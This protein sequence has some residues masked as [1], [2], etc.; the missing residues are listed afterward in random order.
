MTNLPGAH[1]QTTT[2]IRNIAPE[3]RFTTPRSPNA[4]PGKSEV[5]IRPFL[6]PI[7]LAEFL[8]P[9]E[10]ATPRDWE[11]GKFGVA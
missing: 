11:R 1:T 3:G 5:E 9:E 7:G 4:M 10:L 8:T 2:A 6:E